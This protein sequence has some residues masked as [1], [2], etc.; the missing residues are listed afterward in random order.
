MLGQLFGRVLLRVGMFHLA[1]MLHQHAGIDPQRA[2]DGAGAIP[3]ARLDGVVLVVPQQRRGDRR[4]LGLPHHLATEHDPLTRSRGQVAAGTDWFAISAFDAAVDFVLHRGRR[5][6]MVEVGLGIV[7]QQDPRREDVV[8]IRQPLELPHEARELRPPL[9]LDERGD[10]PPRA[11]FR[12]ERSIVFVN[13]Q[14]DDVFHEGIEA[15]GIRLGVQR[16][17]DQEV[18]VARGCMTEYGPFV[19]MLGE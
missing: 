13:H 10:V 5:V 2:C 3:G 16:W 19:A 8:R 14:S 18:Q 15:L 12:L 11:M 7:R 4:A 17:R 6:Q 9:A 1:E